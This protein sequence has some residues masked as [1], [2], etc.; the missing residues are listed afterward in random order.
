MG[1][2]MNPYDAC[3]ANAIIDGKQC[4]VAWYVDD[5]KI[6]HINSKIVDY[7][8]EKIE[9]RVGKMTVTRGKHHVFLGALC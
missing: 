5:N 4:T 7:V 1:F 6:S 3:I 8:I 9:A 2:K